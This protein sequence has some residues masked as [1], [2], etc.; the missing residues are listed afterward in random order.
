MG[1][2]CGMYGE[3]GEVYIGLWLGDPMERDHVEDLAVDGRSYSGVK[4]LL[5]SVSTPF[6]IIFLPCVQRIYLLIIF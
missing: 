4:F 3:R 5:I 2:T 6:Q 1:E